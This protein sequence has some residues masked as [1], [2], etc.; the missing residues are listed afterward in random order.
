MKHKTKNRECSSPESGQAMITAVVLLLFVSVAI[1]LGLGSVVIKNTKITQGF[2][3]SKQSYL[4]AE[5]GVEDIAYR[6]KK[7]KA[8]ASP[9]VL[10]LNGAIATTT[11]TNVGGT[12]DILAIA[13]IGSR[14]RKVKIQ[15]SEATTG[16]GFVY[17]MQV[18]EGG[19]SLEGQA[20]VIGNLYSNGPV[21]GQNNNQNIVRGDIVSAGPSGLI[22]TVWSTSTVRAH[23][24]TN[25]KID[26]DAYY[27]SIDGATIVLGVKYPGSADQATTSMPIAESTI[28]DWEAG[29][30][31]AQVISSPCPYEINANITIGP[32]KI[33]CDL[34]INND[35]TITLGGNIWVAGNIEVTNR[36]TIQIT[37]SFGNKSIAIIADKPSDR[38]TSS[39]IK[40]TN[41]TDYI[42]SGSGNSYVLLLSR[43][44][45]SKLGG[46][47]KA[48]E[49]SNT[50]TGDLLVYSSEGEVELSNNT[51]M[52]EVT[53][54]KIRAKN[55]TKVVYEI[56]LA[57]TLFSAGPSGGS[58]ITGWQEVK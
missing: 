20:E 18:G 6:I 37:P 8:F 47:N 7:S 14:V 13:D 28:D 46:G 15:V 21:T 40:L 29:A 42:G 25:S 36:A 35:P 39:K 32:V 55:S 10:V 34:K 23:S 43:N 44:R 22:D 26:K 19:V 4:T 45:D 33:N 51:N 2:T 50:A 30:A 53:A 24:I 57:S 12:K 1:M 31:A 52:K 56:G 54:Y 5:S 16:V 3:Q 49:V 27:Q 38:I 11:I 58:V 17:G 48:I 41:T 9:E